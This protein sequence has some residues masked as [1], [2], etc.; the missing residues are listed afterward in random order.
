MGQPSEFYFTFVI[1]THNWN[2]SRSFTLTALVLTPAIHLIPME[3]NKI[4]RQ[5][6]GGRDEIPVRSQDMPEI[7]PSLPPQIV[8][9]RLYWYSLSWLLMLIIPQIFGPIVFQPFTHHSPWLW[10]RARH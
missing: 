3:K 9:L 1:P 2:Y 7:L 10:C 5:A 8:P 4:K 6:G